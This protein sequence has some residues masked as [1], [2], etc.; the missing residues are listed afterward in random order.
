MNTYISNVGNNGVKS[1]KRLEI[2]RADGVQMDDSSV[3]SSDYIHGGFRS[4]R[5]GVHIKHVLFCASDVFG[6]GLNRYLAESISIGAACG[7]K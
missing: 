5:N 4:T 1:V 2:C 7:H 6:D 3:C